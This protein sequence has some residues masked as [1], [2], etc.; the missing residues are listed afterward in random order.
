M[1]D[2]LLYA[3]CVWVSAPVSSDF[4]LRLNGHCTVLCVSQLR[5][6]SFPSSP[7]RTQLIQMFSSGRGQLKIEQAQDWGNTALDF[8]WTFYVHPSETLMCHQFNEKSK[9]FKHHSAVF[10]FVCHILQKV[11]FIGMTCFFFTLKKVW[12]ALFCLRLICET[13]SLF[14]ASDLRCHMFSYSTPETV[15]SL[16]FSFVEERVQ[17]KP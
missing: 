4:W 13:V 11:T 5:S 14:Q 17:T 16:D 2:L 10:F 12:I 1:F 15:T 6:C 8:L 9:D 7:D 3:V